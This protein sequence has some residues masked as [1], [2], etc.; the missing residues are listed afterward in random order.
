M[1]NQQSLILDKM[2]LIP[3]LY[4]ERV[5]AFDDNLCENVEYTALYLKVGRNISMTKFSGNNGTLDSAA[6]YIAD[7]MKDCRAY[8]I[9]NGEVPISV[10]SDKSKDLRVCKSR[11]KEIIDSIEKFRR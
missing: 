2:F 1:Q 5:E 3:T 8:N 4:V 9:R 11:L 6:R 10:E 7:R